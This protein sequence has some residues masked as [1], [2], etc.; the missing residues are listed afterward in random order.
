M[1]RSDTSCR[2]NSATPEGCLFC[3]GGLATFWQD[4][5][6]ESGTYTVWRCQS[7]RSGFVWPRPDDSELA[8][9]YASP[10][11]GSPTRKD[12]DS[13]DAAYYP[14]SW[15]DAETIINRCVR[16]AKGWSVLDVGAGNGTFSHVAAKRGFRVSAIE[17]NENAHAVFTEVNGFSPQKRFFDR[18]FA[19][20]VCCSYD[21]ALLSQVLEH[22]PHPLDTVRNLHT[23]LRPGGIAAIAVPHFGSLVSRLQGTNDMFVSPPEHLNFF[24]Q[25]GLTELFA[26]N[27]F[28]VRRIETVSKV[29][30]R[31]IE[32]LARV[33]PLGAVGWRI[34]YAAMRLSDWC[35]AGMVL[36]AY[37]EKMG[38]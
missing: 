18:T 9:L 22:L 28:S 32:R 31:R 7:C 10:A 5:L 35:D 2:S 21:V 3:A 29:P 30:R 8:A 6:T 17:P 34:T 11:Y 13:I 12:A 26:K 38:K 36:N 37:F 33:R 16:L 23:V 1:A 24:S 4:K 20:R 25:R 15:G 27:G 14:T 19:Q